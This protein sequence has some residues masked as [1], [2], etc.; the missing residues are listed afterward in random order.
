MAG[1]TIRRGAC[2]LTPSQPSPLKGEGYQDSTPFH[3]PLEGGGR[4]AKPDGWGWSDNTRTRLN[5]FWPTE[6]KRK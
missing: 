6:R 4:P 3:L 1:Q 5:T 2:R